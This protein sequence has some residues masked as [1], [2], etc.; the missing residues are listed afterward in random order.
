VAKVPLFKP[1]FP[2]KAQTLF[3]NE[4][5]EGRWARGPWVERF[6]E[7]LGTYANRLVVATSSGTMA[8]TLLFEVLRLRMPANQELIVPANAFAT[9]VMEAM[10]IG[11]KPVFVG[12]DNDTMQ[13]PHYD[14]LGYDRSVFVLHFGGGQCTAKT[15]RYRH[16]IHDLA[17][18]FRPPEHASETDSFLWSFHA[19]K[20]VGSLGGGAVGVSEASAYGSIARMADCGREA[21]DASGYTI[22][23]WGTNAR[24]SNLSALVASFTW[25]TWE[26]RRMRRI[27]IANRY[28]EVL[29]EGT[30]RRYEQDDAMHLFVVK[31]K[32]IVDRKIV[33]KDFTEHGIETAVHYP[34]L[35]LMGVFREHVRYDLADTIR[36]CSRVLTVPCHE[37]MTDEQVTVVVNALKRN[38]ARF[39][40]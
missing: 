24:M 34:A 4:L 1:E 33:R 23:E 35:P 40:A 31:T 16:V 25:D 36:L 22:P 2:T 20:P 32:G 9:P 11:W 14:G 39:E 5:R 13:V 28:A 6:E 30:Y 18:L 26:E 3:R 27:A 12:V 17:H 10:R 38:L 29:D 15:N 7:R 8:A 37:G 19:T 21:D